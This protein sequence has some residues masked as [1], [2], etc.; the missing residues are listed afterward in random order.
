MDDGQIR[1]FLRTLYPDDVPN[2]LLLL[3]WTLPG[4]FSFWTDTIDGATKIIFREATSGNDVYL[5]V[6]IAPKTYGKKGRVP[7]SQVA[8][9]PGLWADIDYAHEV[10]SKSGNLPSQEQ[11]LELIESLSLPPTITMHSGHGYQCWWALEKPWVFES[12]SA[13]EQA[14]GIA[15][16]WIYR[17]R[18]KAKQYNWTVDST[19]DLARVMRVPGTMNYKIPD[20][21]VDTKI[22][23]IDAERRY[24]ISQFGSPSSQQG[25]IP[26]DDA[27]QALVLTLNPTA[28]PPSA[29]WMALVDNDNRAL[30]TWQKARK[31]FTDQ[32]ASTYDMSLASLAVAA[33][34]S[35]QEIADLLIAFRRKHGEDLKLREDYYMRTLARARRDIDSRDIQTRLEEAEPGAEP[36]AALP[37]LSALFGIDILNVTKYLGDPPTFTMTVQYKGEQRTVTLGEVGSI[38]NQ[39]TFINKVAATANKIM[40]KTSAPQWVKRAQ[41]LLDSAIEQ[42]LGPESSPALSAQA[43]VDEYLQS[44]RPGDDWHSAVI[45]ARPYVKDETICINLRHITF[46]LKQVQ[47]E[48]IN[49]RE[50]ARYLN[51]AG[52]EQYTQAIPATK[53]QSATTRSVWRKATAA[54]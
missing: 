25:L 29:K 31:D 11:A 50:F 37:S 7:S 22:V 36:G 38:T 13:R 27:R 16:T 40:L 20:A 39:A 30:K 2:G 19:I 51:M 9:I 18:D 33:N 35:D 3:V 49:A 53:E 1:T 14:A 47:G 12:E 15:R 45:A 26:S 52:W 23:T 8:G 44:H 54:L 17:I 41:V 32:S 10:H 46:W 4:K 5:G 6:G 48:R 28:E 34:W 24:K 21:I 43:M 42:E